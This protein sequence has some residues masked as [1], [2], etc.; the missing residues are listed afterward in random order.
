MCIRDSW[1]TIAGMSVLIDRYL[2]GVLSRI[3]ERPLPMRGETRI[4][5]AF[6]SLWAGRIEAAQADLREAEEEMKW[7]AVSGELAWSVNL[8]HMFFDAMSG[9]AGAVQTRL[10]QRIAS[11]DE[12]PEEQ[13]RFWRHQTAIYAVRLNG[14]LGGDPVALRRWAGLI[15]ENPLEDATAWNLSLIHI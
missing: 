3:G 1:T 8:F 6:Q 12:A 4:L 10:E 13:R 9:H 5:R 15:R 14:T 2:A 7:L 11:Y